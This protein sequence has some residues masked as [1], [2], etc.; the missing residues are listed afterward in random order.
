MALIITKKA[1]LHRQKDLM[2]GLETRL[3]ILYIV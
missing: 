3:L 2:Y 1:F